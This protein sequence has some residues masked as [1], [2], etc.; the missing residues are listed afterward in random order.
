M[1]HF[2]DT[3]ETIEPGQGFTHFEPEHLAWLAAFVLAALGTCA[4]PAFGRR[5]PQAHALGDGRPSVAQRSL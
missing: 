5:R 4:L 3:V 2:L 1:E